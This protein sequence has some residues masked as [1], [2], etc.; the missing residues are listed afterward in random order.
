MNNK[1]LLGLGA[2]LL[3][4]VVS[5]PQ[6]LKQSK[7]PVQI[8]E[9]PSNDRAQSSSVLSQLSEDEKSNL[10]NAEIVWV[11]PKSRPMLKLEDC[12]ECSQKP[13][14]VSEVFFED[15]NLKECI[16]EAEIGDLEDFKEIECGI[17]DDIRSIT[18]LEHFPN[19]ISLRLYKYNGQTLDTSILPNLEKLYVHEGHFQSLNLVNNSELLTLELDSAPQLF[20]V[21]I[22]QNNK[23]K[24]FTTIETSLRQ[25]DLSKNPELDELFIS[26]T[27]VSKLN[28]SNNSVLRVLHLYDNPIDDLKIDGK[29]L[30]IFKLSGTPLT[31]VD[32]TKM[33]NLSQLSISSGPLISI[34]ISNN[35]ALSSVSFADT[36]LEMLDTSKNINLSKLNLNRSSIA[37][38]NL[39]ENPK[40]RKLHLFQTNVKKLDLSENHRLRRIWLPS[41]FPRK[42]VKLSKKAEEF[43]N[44]E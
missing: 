39:A 42:K 19:L 38:L 26:K 41:R 10:E 27:K 12:S 29:G 5:A 11:Q 24:K 22:T 7:T 17:S 8:S 31:T 25:V 1:F 20:D 43:V 30:E 33:E 36:E 40:L 6:L 9:T 13:Q 21:N 18:G 23:L 34:D 14:R 44:F 4:V 16:V 37:S 35:K 3:L 2:V 28:L 32:L 15:P